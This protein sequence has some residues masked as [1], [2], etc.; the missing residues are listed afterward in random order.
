M[1]IEDGLI[2]LAMSVITGLYA[3]M[4]VAKHSE[5]RSLRENASRIVNSSLTAKDCANEL[6]VIVQSLKRLG[7]GRS[8]I[9]LEQVAAK[10]HKLYKDADISA[11]NGVAL[12]RLD[13]AVYLNDRQNKLRTDVHS[14]KPDILSLV[15]PFWKWVPKD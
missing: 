10:Y 4:I 3:G 12:P 2:S 8:A 9:V 5:F 11:N 14:L 15:A 13:Y 1:T 6:H 7:H